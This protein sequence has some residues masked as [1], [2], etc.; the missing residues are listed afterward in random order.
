MGGCCVLSR[1]RVSPDR[2]SSSSR[3]KELRAHDV[4]PRVLVLLLSPSLFSPV[5]LPKVYLFLDFAAAQPKRRLRWIPTQSQTRSSMHL[6]TSPKQHV[7]PALTL[8]DPSVAI[9]PSVRPCNQHLRPCPL[10]AMRCAIETGTPGAVSSHR[11]RP[12]PRHRRSARDTAHSTL[13]CT[14]CLSRSAR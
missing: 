12:W 4:S 9:R 6:A 1:Y 10:A 8:L 14:H 3:H 13:H 2:S 7:H 11:P 5:A